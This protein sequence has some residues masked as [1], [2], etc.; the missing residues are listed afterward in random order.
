MKP[1]LKQPEG[2]IVH[3]EIF[4][5][6]G[7]EGK[8]VCGARWNNGVV[9]EF[10]SYEFESKSWSLTKWHFCSIDTWLQGICR[11]FH[12]QRKWNK[13]EVSSVKLIPSSA[14][15]EEEDETF[16]EDHD[17]FKKS[18]VYTPRRCDERKADGSSAHFVEIPR[19]GRFTATV[20][21]INS[22]LKKLAKYTPPAQ[23]S[24]AC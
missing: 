18:E 8:R 10:D 2:D 19:Y 16:S 11:S 23:G 12:P 15:E 21:A 20:C 22:G 24:I 5:G 7:T 6:G 13:L 1:G 3:V 9:Q 4:L 14:A 17:D